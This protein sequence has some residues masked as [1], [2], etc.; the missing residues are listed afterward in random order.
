LEIVV[1][2]PLYGLEIYQK[3]LENFGI[4]FSKIKEKLGQLRAIT[5]IVSPPGH[6]SNWYFMLVIYLSTDIVYI[7]TTSIIE[8]T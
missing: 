1:V 4:F 2:F 6:Y 3:N 5:D 8:P 7:H